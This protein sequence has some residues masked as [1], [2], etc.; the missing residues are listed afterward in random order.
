MSKT[1]NAEKQL[2]RRQSANEFKA[3]LSALFNNQQMQ[4]LI[5]QTF[6]QNYYAGGTLF[7]RFLPLSFSVCDR[8]ALLSVATLIRGKTTDFWNQHG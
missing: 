1:A 8:S 3:Q 6:Q 5:G 2:V 7:D 4:S